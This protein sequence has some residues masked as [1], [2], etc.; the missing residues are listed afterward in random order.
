MSSSDGFNPAMVLPDCIRVV[1][2]PAKFPAHS[3]VTVSSRWSWRPLWVV[4]YDAVQDRGVGT[5]PIVPGVVVFVLPVWCGPGRP[6]VEAHGAG[7][8][9][10]EL[11]GH[12]LRVVLA[13]QSV[14]RCGAATRSWG[15]RGTAKAATVLYLRGSNPY[16]VCLEEN[17]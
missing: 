16:A 15:T 11:V 5:V 12:A 6:A 3:R 1:V 4:E 8:V 13:V 10:E 17:R 7:G 2:D 14:S 9:D